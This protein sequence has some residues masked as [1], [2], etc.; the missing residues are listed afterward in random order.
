VS[1]PRFHPEARQDFHEAFAFLAE[2]S[3]AVA[4]R[5]ASRVT[6]TLELIAAFPDA[7]RPLS[8][9]FRAVPLHPFSHDLVYRI[10]ADGHGLIFAVAHHRRQPGYWRHRSHIT[11][12]VLALDGEH[13]LQVSAEEVEALELGVR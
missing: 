2:Q 9:P 11:G 8:G 7:G 10:E 3:P 12:Q 13:A 5:F 1:P 4:R 6:E